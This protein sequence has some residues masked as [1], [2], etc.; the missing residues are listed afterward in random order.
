VAVLHD[1]KVTGSPV[2]DAATAMIK[3]LLADA[4]W[5]WYDTEAAHRLVTIKVLFFSKAVR[6]RDLL[7]V[8]EMLFGTHP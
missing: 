5:K 2:S 8:F 1:L 3:Q 6:V 4:F 7:S